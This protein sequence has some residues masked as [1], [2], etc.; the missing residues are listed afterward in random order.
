MKTFPVGAQ[1][2]HAEG[3]TDRRTD[4]HDEV[5][6]L[7]AILRTRLKKPRPNFMTHRRIQHMSRIVNMKKIF[8]QF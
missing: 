3:R 6:C 4:R 7:S 5:N 8:C 1:S 2:L